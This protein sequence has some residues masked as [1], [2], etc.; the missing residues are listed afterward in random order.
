MW[1][2]RDHFGFV[3]QPASV[4]VLGLYYETLATIMKDTGCQSARQGNFV[5][6]WEESHGE[7]KI[8]RGVEPSPEEPIMP[9]PW[10]GVTSLRQDATEVLAHDSR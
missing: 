3:F 9:G 10:Q 4:G 8:C 7:L 5:A 6:K 1:F 2:L